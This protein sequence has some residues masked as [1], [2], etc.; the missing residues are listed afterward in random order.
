MVQKSLFSYQINLVQFLTFTL[1]IWGSLVLDKS[2]K[3]LWQSINVLHMA[4]GAMIMKIGLGI[5]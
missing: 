3:S 5:Y 1:Y 4:H 2:A